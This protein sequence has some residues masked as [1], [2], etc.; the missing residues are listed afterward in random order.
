MYEKYV[1]LILELPWFPHKFGWRNRVKVALGLARLL[2]LCHGNAPNY[3]VRNL[4][5]AHVIV[6]KDFNPILVDFAMICGGGIGDNHFPS[7]LHRP[8]ASYG[9]FDKDIV[10]CDT[11]SSK[12][13]TAIGKH[14]RNLPFPLCDINCP[15]QFHILMGRYV[16]YLC[17]KFSVV[18]AGRWVE[19]T[20][21][22]IF[23]VV[24]LELILKDTS[25]E[26]MRLILKRPIKNKHYY[27]L[28]E[29][30]CGGYG[31]ELEKALNGEMRHILVRAHLQRDP[32]YDADDGTK[33]SMLALR[34]V[35]YSRPTM[36]EVVGM[37]EEL[38]VVTKHGGMA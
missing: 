22:Y 16:V 20:D 21:V 8:V 24:V 10:L 37:L 5:A 4:S 2:K 18:S 26:L 12:T 34:C 14:H 32:D 3:L 13:P 11:S 17:I 1:L 7:T 25:D 38:H 31:E 27:I 15:M 19:S 36:Q 29:I 33:I 9:Y 6:D 30:V 28:D 23:G 35:S